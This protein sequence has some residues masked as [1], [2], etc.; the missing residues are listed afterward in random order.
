MINSFVGLFRWET[1]QTLLRLLV[2]Y[3]RAHSPEKHKGSRTN[4][5]LLW[6]FQ[7]IKPSLI[8][9]SIPDHGFVVFSSH[10]AFFF[11]GEVHSCLKLYIWPPW[12]SEVCYSYFSSTS[13]YC[14]D[15]FNFLDLI[16]WLKKVLL[17]TCSDAR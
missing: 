14:I 17:S 5:M 3:F 11:L 1:Q 13:P 9:S 15:Y 10:F 7:L 4:N 2:K 16:W 6:A 12:L 8:K